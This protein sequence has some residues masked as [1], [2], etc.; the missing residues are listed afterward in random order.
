MVLENKLEKHQEVITRILELSD[1][2]ASGLDHMAKQLAEIRYEESFA[3]LND[4]VQG[5]YAI[6]ESLQQFINDLPVNKLEIYLDEL[7]KEIDLLITNY[8]QKEAAAIKEEIVTKIPILYL[9]WQNELKQ[10]L[11]PYVLV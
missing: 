2:I 4:S 10:V 1:T 3:M 7:K 6:E 9:Q 11:Q 5:I 8:E